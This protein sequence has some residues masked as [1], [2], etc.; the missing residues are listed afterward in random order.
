[1]N[2]EKPSP[3]CPKCGGAMVKAKPRAYSIDVDLDV[4][5]PVPRGS[6]FWRKV[7]GG[8]TRKLTYYICVTCGYVE[9]YAQRK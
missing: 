3:K 6:R 7:K 2:T 5:M 1:M 9:I 4:K 8:D